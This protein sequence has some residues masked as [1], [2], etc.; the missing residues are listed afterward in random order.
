MPKKRASWWYEAPIMTGLWE[1]ST[2]YISIVSSLTL[3]VQG[4]DSTTQTCDLLVTW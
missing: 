3:H 4:A 1:G 2:H